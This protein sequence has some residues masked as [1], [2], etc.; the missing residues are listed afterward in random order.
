M[1]EIKRM[2][3]VFAFVSAACAAFGLGAV[4]ASADTGADPCAVSNFFLCRMMPISPELDQ[5]IDLT[6]PT[7]TTTA[8]T[9]APAEL[10]PA[11][12]GWIQRG[13]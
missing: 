5:D 2:T 9:V 10:A 3:R 13:R 7:Q 6:A 8:A 4:D 12:A 11:P 1:H